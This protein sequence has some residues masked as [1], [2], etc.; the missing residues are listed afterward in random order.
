M[1]RKRKGVKR[2]PRRERRM[3]SES[4]RYARIKKSLERR[5]SSRPSVF[6]A[7]AICLQRYI[8]NYPDIKR[9]LRMLGGSYS[10][11]FISENEARDIYSLYNKGNLV[12]E[13]ERYNRG[14]DSENFPSPVIKAVVDFFDQGMYERLRVE[15][16]ELRA[17]RKIAKK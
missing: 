12:E 15:P 11:I 5:T 6:E 14:H 3:F 17:Y 16:E 4:G 8:N 2:E 1:G 10:S 9:D 7:M 13:L